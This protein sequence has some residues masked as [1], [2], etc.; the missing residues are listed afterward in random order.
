MPR[1]VVNEAETNTAGL[2]AADDS[3]FG[4]VMLGLFVVLIVAMVI[5][6][7]V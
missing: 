7:L 2:R 5:A 6:S 1:R 4:Q 3:I